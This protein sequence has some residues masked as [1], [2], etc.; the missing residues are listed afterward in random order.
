M[1]RQAN[2]TR[3]LDG[4]LRRGD[5]LPVQPGR[6]LVGVLKARACGEESGVQVRQ[7]L[8]ANKRGVLYLVVKRR[9]CRYRTRARASDRAASAEEEEE[10]GTAASADAAVAAAAQ[11]QVPDEGTAGRTVRRAC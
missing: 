1:L 10:P 6:V 9:V 11:P 7:W 3:L 8:R 2:S 4:L 5:L